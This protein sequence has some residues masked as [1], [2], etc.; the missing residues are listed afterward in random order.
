[1]SSDDL[2]VLKYFEPQEQILNRP[3]PYIANFTPTGLMTIAWDRLM[4][5]IEK[6]ER[7]PPTLVAVDPDFM[8]RFNEQSFDPRRLLTR[9]SRNETWFNDIEANRLMRVM[10]LDAL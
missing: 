8:D 5:P 1:M 6:P 10:L 4:Q 3:I 7:I 2:N 9:V